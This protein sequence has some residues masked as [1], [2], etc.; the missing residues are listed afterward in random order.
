MPPRPRPEITS[1][2]GPDG[3]FRNL[4][5]CAQRLES[6]DWR[7]V[8]VLL[9][10]DG[11]SKHRLAAVARL[12]ALSMLQQTVGD[13]ERAWTI[14]IEASSILP[15][16]VTSRDP[17]TGQVT[18][19][20]V[21]LQERIAAREQGENGHE[22]RLTCALADITWREQTEL[23]QLQNRS[24][25]YPSARDALIRACEEHL[26]WIEFAPETWRRQIP[27]SQLQSIGISLPRKYHE[28]SRKN[29]CERA[30]RLRRFADPQQG[31]VSDSV[32]ADIG[33]YAGLKAAA[34]EVL[35]SR[36][37]DSWRLGPR[38]ASLQHFPVRSGCTSAWRFAQDCSAPTPLN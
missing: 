20:V 5:R 25:L 30:S 13:V 15:P 24:H 36:H 38:Y 16:A 26:T 35:G 32:W 27:P 21:P 1:P 8:L 19:L 31:D 3:P 2:Y 10:S 4:H 14:L 9:A 33:G 22:R 11:S 28:P 6:G 34:L 17:D 29:L 37:S 7:E 23:G 18:A 12:I